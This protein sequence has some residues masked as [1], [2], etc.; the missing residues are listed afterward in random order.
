MNNPTIIIAHNIK[1]RIRIKMSHPLRNEKEVVNELLKRD[2]INDVVYNK[3]TKSI[4]F[5]YSDYKVPIDELI[6]RFV[7]AYS[8]DFDLIPIRFVHK[9]SSKK[10]P[11][12]T[13]YSLATI[14]IGSVSKYITTN[15][16]IHDF[17]NW[18]AVG[19]TLGAIG[20]HAY[21]EINER[22]YFDPEIVSV[23]YLIN[24]ISKG[25]FLSSSAITWLTTFG[26]HLFDASN[27]RIMI[28]VREIKN[29][30]TLES[31]YDLLVVPDLDRKKR[32]N[33]LKMFL[34]KFIEGQ[35][36]TMK[37]NFVLTSNELVKS[38]DKIL[39]GFEKGPSLMVIGEKST[40]LFN[41]ALR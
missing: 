10:I 18:A 36:S 22:G 12:M 25:N 40:K 1:D 39:S 7:V 26:R 41:N 34:E 31:Y 28:N 14:I 6:M 20:E 13:Y 38:Q 9:L 21:N 15:S 35:G 33:T 11:P 16:N 29:Q 3:I 5:N 30:T 27:G 37:K 4:V 19:T 17:L 23:M 24:S 2:G 8:K 32:T